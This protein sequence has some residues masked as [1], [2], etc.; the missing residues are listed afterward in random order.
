MIDT[1]VVKD[2]SGTIDLCET[3]TYDEI[4]SFEIEEGKEIKGFKPTFGKENEYIVIFTD[5]TTFTFETEKLI[6][7]IEIEDDTLKVFVGE[8]VLK[9]VET[10]IVYGSSVIDV[11]E[12]FID[13]KPYSRFTY[14]E[15]D[16]IS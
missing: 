3:F 8:K 16:K 12:G 7:L 11:I 15:V 9:Q 5:D 6:G 13:D 2:E 1:R 10:N 4:L 14:E